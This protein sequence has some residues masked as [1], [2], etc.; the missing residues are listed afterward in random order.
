MKKKVS[1]FVLLIVTLITLSGCM[2]LEYS[3]TINKDGSGEITYLCAINKSV[4][5]NLSKDNVNSTENLRENA[6]NAGYTTE[7]Y[8]DDETKGFIATKKVS[9]ITEKSY[10]KEIFDEYVKNE[11]ESKI[12]IK[13][14]IFGKTY[15]QKVILDMKSVESLKE[16]GAKCE[17]TINLPEKVSE[18]NADNIS[19]DGKTLTWN[20]NLGQEQEIYFR[21]T[22]GR[23]YSLLAM[24]VI[25][26]IALVIILVI[27]LKI[28]KNKGK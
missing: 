19:N 21:A 15:S 1:L 11:E 8:E 23:I 17:Y 18:T 7:D 26:V 9:N 28:I 4:I 22:S 2:K 6:K 14:S 3:T 24:A 20:L 12:E 27:V 13:N 5:P 16:L 10:I 25:V